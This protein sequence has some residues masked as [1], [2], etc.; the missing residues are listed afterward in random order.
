[1]ITAIYP[2]EKG[3][4]RTSEV[5]EGGSRTLRSVTYLVPLE[6]DCHHTDDSERQRLREGEGG[7]SEERRNLTSPAGAS[8]HNLPPDTSLTLHRT[9]G[10]SRASFPP[11]GTT[12][13]CSIT[14]EGD[15]E[16]PYMLPSSPSPNLSVLSQ[17]SRGEESEAGAGEPVNR[18]RQ[19]RAAVVRQRGLMQILLNDDLL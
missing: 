10:S 8:G 3:V 9:S 11:V 4:V 16:T 6:L 1:M 19:P 17:T 14:T 5:E 15:T 2:D 13:Q 18:A 12:E 7:D